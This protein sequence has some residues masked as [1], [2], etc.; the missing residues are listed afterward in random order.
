[1][2]IYDS[3][4][5]AWGLYREPRLNK[6]DSASLSLNAT[7]A[8]GM[9]SN[10]FQQANHCVPLSPNSIDNRLVITPNYKIRCRT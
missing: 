9:S 8:N 1:M 3:S 7:G 4:Q 5:P 10:R 2:F 6:S